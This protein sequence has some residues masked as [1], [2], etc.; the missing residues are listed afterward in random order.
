MTSATFSIIDA[1][2]LKGLVFR[3]ECYVSGIPA[4]NV[5]SIDY[6]RWV[7]ADPKAEVGE[8]GEVYKEDDSEN[9]K[10]LKSFRKFGL[11]IT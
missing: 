11:I 10:V 4:T 5:Y 3:P 9:M 7:L 1:L 6:D 8:T 2:P